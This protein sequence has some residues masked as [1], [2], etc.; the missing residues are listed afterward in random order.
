[1]PTISRFFGIVIAMYFDDHGP[2]HFHARHAEGGAKVRIDT[3]EVIDSSLGRRQMRFVL[4]CAE[5]HRDE[6][7]ENWS[8]ARLGDTLQPIDPLR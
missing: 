6:L 8:R 4:A 1:V 3:L 5:L 7:L 2:P